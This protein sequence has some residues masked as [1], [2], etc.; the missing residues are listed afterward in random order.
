MIF[1]RGPALLCLERTTIAR[2]DDHLHLGGTRL[3]LSVVATPHPE[4]AQSTE[5]VDEQDHTLHL[6]QIGD[7]LPVRGAHRHEDDVPEIVEAEALRPAVL[8]EGEIAMKD[9]ADVD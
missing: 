1:A 4:V 3:Y 6:A 7:P 9:G 8:V 2:A 5:G